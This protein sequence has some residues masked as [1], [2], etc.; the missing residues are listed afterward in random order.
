MVGAASWDFPEQAV[1]ATRSTTTL[2]TT[3]ILLLM[4][5]REL[6]HNGVQCARGRGCHIPAT[7]IVDYG[8]HE[9]EE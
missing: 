1:S 8:V 2:P 6:S 7:S 3:Q 5:S 9:M 4:A